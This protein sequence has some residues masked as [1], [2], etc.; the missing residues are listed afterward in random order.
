MRNLIIPPL[1]LLLMLCIVAGCAD[2]SRAKAELREGYSSLEARQYDQA[3]SQAEAFLQHTPQGPGSAEALYLKGR[4]L[5]QKSAANINQARADL[6]AAREAYL[7]ALAHSPSPRLTA[8]IHTSLANVAYFQE[9]YPSAITE[10]SN[11]YDKLENSEVK[12]WVLY[13]LGLCYQRMGQ[14]AQADENFVRVQQDFSGSVPAQRAKEHQGIRGF[15]VQLATFATIQP[16]DAAIATL[17]REG[18]LANRQTDA[19]GHSVVMVGPMPSY[20]QAQALKARYSARYPAA[21]VI[22]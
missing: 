20:A 10:W 6:Q 3:Q 21:V 17:R 22:P 19:S 7:Q 15:S 4:A 1:G 5:E 2:D 13:R 12:A 14:F 11:A 8:Y 18:V 9:D 16:A